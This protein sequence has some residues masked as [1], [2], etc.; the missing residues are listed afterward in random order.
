MFYDRHHLTMKPLVLFL[1]LCQ[2]MGYCL[3]I[4]D[5][6]HPLHNH[7]PSLL[8]ILQKETVA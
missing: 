8:L 1:S 4:F 6:F 2:A 7:S 3:C 5:L